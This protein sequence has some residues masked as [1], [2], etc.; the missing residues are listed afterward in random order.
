MGGCICSTTARKGE[1][2][3]WDMKEKAGLEH[4]QRVIPPHLQTLSVN[5]VNVLVEKTYSPS[6]LCNAQTNTGQIQFDTN[7]PVGGSKVTTYT[8]LTLISLQNSAFVFLVGTFTFGRMYGSVA[9]PKRSFPCCFSWK[10]VFPRNQMSSENIEIFIDWLGVIKFH[11]KIFYEHEH[12]KRNDAC[13]ADSSNVHLWHILQGRIF[14]I[15][16]N[17][18]GHEIKETNH[19][20]FDSQSLIVNGYEPI[21][22]YS[23]GVSIAQ[24]SQWF[25]P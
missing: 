4:G 18:C 17:H 12:V 6:R 21:E 25:W 2:G 14:S 19:F 15:N 13:S 22:L 24:I 10:G 11:S 5:E 23:S 16:M 1:G 3:E 9:V 7:I 8:G 20:I